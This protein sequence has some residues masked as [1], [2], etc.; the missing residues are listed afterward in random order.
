MLIQYLPVTEGLLRNPQ[1]LAPPTDG[2]VV[3]SVSCYCCRY[4]YRLMDILLIHSENKTRL[5]GEEG[6][7]SWESGIEDDESE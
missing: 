4:P 1:L 5:S 6:K 3:E 2:G 7:L